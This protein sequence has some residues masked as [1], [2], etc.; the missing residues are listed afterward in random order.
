[1]IDIYVGVGR[2]VCVA[3]I[4]AA[5]IALPLHESANDLK[6][7]DTT[8]RL[9]RTELFM[10]ANQQNIPTVK[11][12][13]EVDG[14]HFISIAGSERNDGQA[15]NHSSCAEVLWSSLGS[16]IE[17]TCGNAT[18]PAL[19]RSTLADLQ[20]TTDPLVR[21]ALGSLLTEPTS[22]SALFDQAGACLA[23]NRPLAAFACWWLD[24]PSLA[25]RFTNNPS[26]VDAE[27]CSVLNV[28]VVLQRLGEAAV[29]E[30]AVLGAL[31]AGVATQADDI[32]LLIHDQPMSTPCAPSQSKSGRCSLLHRRETSTARSSRSSS[33]RTSP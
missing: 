16:K 4:A 18:S 1:M 31:M 6:R 7:C 30:P 15:A 9:G 12:A 33:R 5:A 14:P 19:I 32:L 24:N 20:M 26:L 21:E 8:E 3:L 10:I 29:R 22:F 23:A 17:A 28:A 27:L 13:T 25:P 11:R 2:A